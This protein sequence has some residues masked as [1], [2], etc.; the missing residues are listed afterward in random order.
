M[1]VSPPALL[2]RRDDAARAALA[3]AARRAR[4]VSGAH[5]RLVEVP[6]PLGD[7]IPGRGL[8]RG[9]VV[10]VDGAP[11]AGATSVVFAL[12]AAITAAGEWA[13]AVDLDATFGA[14]A[15]AE[16]GVA[17]DRFAV[18]RPPGG[19][20]L[21]PDRW[22]TTVAALLDGVSLVVAE[23]PRS[24][25]A[26]DARRLVARAREREVILVPFARGAPWPAEAALRVRATGGAWPGL[27][28]GSGVLADRTVRVEVEGRGVAARTRTG[29]WAQTRVGGWA[30]SRAG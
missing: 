21:P 4:P 27:A 15:A 13:A 14:L 12:A 10:A 19:G 7:L 29:G 9:S 11:G 6:G 2:P 26:A 23:V 17:L 18:V 24:V 20:S 16:A 28:A 3:D 1:A 30:T 8:R 22:A 5:E 25:R